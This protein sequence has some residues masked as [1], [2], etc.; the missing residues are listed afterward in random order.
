MHGLLIQGTNNYASL[1]ENYVN[2][3]F[4]HQDVVYHAEYK[5]QNCFRQKFIFLSFSYN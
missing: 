2:V 5:Y 4:M 3:W 1:S